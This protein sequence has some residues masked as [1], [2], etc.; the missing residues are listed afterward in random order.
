MKVGSKVPQFKQKQ[1][2]PTNASQMHTLRNKV[3]QFIGNLK[4]RQEYEPI[5]GPLVQN[6]KAES[7]HLGNNCWGH[8]FKKVLTTI[9]ANAKVGTNV[10]SVFQLPEDNPLRKHLKTFRF[11][12]TCKKIV[13]KVSPLV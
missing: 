5:L 8:W 3:C 4:S 1:T 12:L 11:K 7:L 6:A 9:L 2:K 13:Q 10:K